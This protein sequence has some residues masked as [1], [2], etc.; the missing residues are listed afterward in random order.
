MAVPSRSPT[1]IA[2]GWGPRIEADSLALSKVM[3]GLKEVAKFMAKLTVESAVQFKKADETKNLIY[4][5]TVGPQDALVL[6]VGWVY[7]ERTQPK[8]DVFGLKSILL[9][10]SDLSELERWNKLWISQQ[11]PSEA[12]N[13]VIDMLTLLE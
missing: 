9:R 3:P 11:S 5:L 8:A 4:H 2:V 13:R 10:A 1:S 7:A 6:P 12:L